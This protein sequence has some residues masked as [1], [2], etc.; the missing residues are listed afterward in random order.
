M[1]V[2]VTCLCAAWLCLSAVAVAESPTPF[3]RFTGERVYVAGVPNQYRDLA[4]AIAT[5]ERKS[6]QTYYVAVVRYT[7]RSS[8]PTAD[9]VDALYDRWMAESQDLGKPIDPARSVVIVLAINNR[10]LAMHPGSELAGKFGLSDQ[11]IER[12]LLQPHFVPYARSGSYAAGLVELIEQT[13]AWVQTREVARAAEAAA[14]KARAERIARDAETALAAAPQAIA[15]ARRDLAAKHAEGLNP[16]TF[17]ASLKRADDLVTTAKVYLTSNP[18]QSLANA[19]EATRLAQHVSG[20]MQLFAGR[21]AQAQQKLEAARTQQ[22]QVEVSLRR[23]E[24]AGLVTTELVARSNAAAKQIEAAVPFI[25]SDPLRAISLLDAAARTHAE[26]AAASSALPARRLAMQSS[27]R[28]VMHLEARVS[29]SLATAQARGWNLSSEAVALAGAKK[30]IAHASD[31]ASRDYDAAA[32]EYAPLVTQLQTI[33]RGIAS[34]VAESEFLYVTLPLSLLIVAVIL[35]SAVL[36]GLGY[37]ARASRR[38]ADQAFAAFKDRVIGFSDGIDALRERHRLLPASDPDFQAPMVGATLAAYQEIQTQLERLRGRWLEIMDVWERAGALIKAH[39]W[40][41]ATAGQSVVELVQGV[42]ELTPE[43][44]ELK[45]H[46]EEPLA[47]LE[48][49][50]EAAEA[51]IQDV[52]GML[53]ARDEDL[54]RLSSVGLPTTPFLPDRNSL[55]AALADA[56]AQLTPDPLGAAEALQAVLS[57]AEAF[58]ERLATAIELAEQ[59]H[60]LT[61]QFDDVSKNIERHRQTGCR[62]VEEEGQPDPWLQQARVQHRLAKAT[63]DHGELPAAAAQLAEAGDLAARAQQVLEQQLATEEV[64]RI[65]HVERPNFTAQLRTLA[66]QA[67][68]DQRTLEA[69]YAPQSWQVVAGNLTAAEARLATFDPQHAAAAAAAAPEQQRYFRA[70]ALWNTLAEQQHDVEQGLTAIRQVLAQLEGI[71]QRCRHRLPSMRRDIASVEAEYELNRSIVRREAAQLIA[72]LDVAHDRAAQQAAFDRPDW[73][74]IDVALAEAQAILDTVHAVI[75]ADIRTFHEL[76]QSLAELRVL[77]D[78]VSHF[79]ETN[80]ADRPQSNE[81][82]R[83]WNQLLNTMLEE[84]RQ[85]GGEWERLLARVRDVREGFEQADALARQDVQLYQQVAAE[86][87]EAEQYLQRAESFYRSGYRADC[88]DAR[89]LLTAARQAAQA[90]DYEQAIRLANQSDRASQ[91]A[92]ARAD[93]DA[94]QH[95]EKIA[96]QRRLYEAAQQAAT[97]AIL[98]GGMGSGGGRSRGSKNSIFSGSSSSGSSSG[99][100]SSSS[101]SRSGSTRF[102]SST[103]SVKW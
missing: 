68:R 23:Q 28:E 20:E 92:I 37:R 96:Q 76:Q 69:E 81:R 26:V 2:R 95:E 45:Q 85:T 13:D 29:K 49:A 7:G 100:R 90:S 98:I 48:S 43:L 56:E 84:S 21:Q 82:F 32:N 61:S 55:E 27:Q 64:A 86:L 94:K 36:A 103:G 87:R 15:Q 59:H 88:A 6:Q 22:T 52:Q 31:L 11:T 17:E 34:S 40:L 54:Q 101:R 53:A 66:E 67:T 79:L 80:T 89:R 33:E 38:R 91:D 41:S 51:M 10:E 77:R 16:E 71:R 4:D 25:Q 63:L 50:H 70:V 1:S 14:I 102:G 83:S 60:A 99:S 12:D 47:R 5:V 73:P 42:A 57:G 8:T 78:R 72:K 75:A 39:G 97:A 19:Q 3:P 93:W 44:V 9:Y 18:A 65:A 24:S 30:R 58:G 35:V 62:F 46:V 74:A